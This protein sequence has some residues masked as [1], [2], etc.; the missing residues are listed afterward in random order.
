M[1]DP[2]DRAV[3]ARLHAYRLLSGASQEAFARRL[4]IS[5][6]QLQKYEYGFNRIAAG[7]LYRMT[8]L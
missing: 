6:Q 1:T 3:G 8:R 7:R 4:D 5:Y 2:V